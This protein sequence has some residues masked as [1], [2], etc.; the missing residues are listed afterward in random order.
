MKTKPLVRRCFNPTLWLTI[1]SLAFCLS[2]RA[3]TATANWSGAVNNDWNTAGN[4]DILGVPGV[5]TNAVIGIGTTANYDAPM[6]ATNLAGVNNTG[7]LTINAAGFN[8]DALG[9]LPAYFGNTLSLLRIT[10]NGVFVATNSTTITFNTD[11]TN[12]VDGGVLLVT[13]STG[14]IAFG[15][16]G[17]NNG[18][19]FT[20]NGG[21]VMFSQPFQSKG[22]FSRFEVHGGSLALLGGGGILE[23]SNDQERRFLIDGGTANLGNFSISRTL[24]TPIGSAGLVISNNATVTVSSL[25]IGT[26]A[27]AA[28]ATIYGGVLTNTGIFTISDRTNGATS[29]QRRIFLYVRGGTVVST[30]PSGIVIANQPNNSNTGGSSVW[31]GF[32]DINAGTIIAEQLTL[33]GTS[34][35]TNAYAT[36]TLAAPGAVYLGSG[37]LV[38]NVGYS[39]TS[40][41]MSLGGTLGAKA[42]YSI[43]GNGTLTG[44]FT[45][46]A[47]DIAN[48][49]HNVTNTGVWSGSGALVKTGGGVL[50]L[51]A[52]NTYSGTTTV[53]AGALVLGP[54]GSISNTTSIAVSSGGVFDVSAISGAVLLGSQILGGSGAVNGSI[55]ALP[56]SSIRPGGLLAAG[57]LTFSNTLALGGNVTLTFDLSDDPSGT[58][59]TNDTVNVLGSLNLS[60]TNVIAINP[61]S[62]TPAPGNVYRLIRYGTALTGGVGNLTLAGISGIL[63]NDVAGKAIV[64]VVQSSTRAPANVTWLGGLGGN[65]WDTIIT[66]NWLNGAARDIFVTGDNARFDA[67]GVANGAVTVVGS[68]NPTALVVDTAS[69]YVFSGS[70][71]ID[72]AGGLTKTNTGTLTILTTNGYSGPTMIGAG[73]IEAIRVAPGGLS[74]SLGSAGTDPANLQ[75]FDS[76]LRYLGSGGSTDR[77]ATLNGTAAALDVTNASAALTISGNLVGAAGLTKAG[78]GTLILSG[79]SG[80]AGLTTLSNGTLQVNNAVSALGTNT[81]VFVGG[82]VSFNVSGQPTYPNALNVLTSGGMTSAGGNNNIVTGPWSGAGTLNLSVASGT[83]SIGA[84]MTTNFTGTILLTTNSTGTFRFN[85]GGS[86]PSKGSTLV[87]FDLGN[88]SA[89]LVNRNGSTYGT[90]VYYLGGLAGGPN[91]TLRGSAN[92]GTPNAYEIG[93]NNRNTTFAG[94]IANGAGGSAALVSLVKAGTGTLTLSGTNTYGGSTIISNGVLALSGS[95]TI[96]ISPTINLLAGAALDTSARTDGALPLADGQTLLGEGTVRGSVTVQSNATLSPGPSAGTIGKMVITNVLT[97]QPGGMLAM[98][99]D[100]NAATNDVI[101]GLTKVI[102]GGALNLTIYSVDLTSSFRLFKAASYSGG[103]DLINPNIPAPGWVWDVSSL[104]VNGTLKVKTLVITVPKIANASISGTNITLSGIGGAPFYGYVVYSSAD[105][106]QPLSSWTAVGNGN[107]RGDGSFV[108]TIPIDPSASEQFYSVQYSAP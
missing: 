23:T 105:V 11:S 47:A 52:N 24:N 33:V 80:Y 19:G 108:F 75:L 18:A 101:E 21:V 32:L 104:G 1:I 92:N 68:V 39:N 43:V 25:Q 5:G 95:G 4:W 66:S 76:T 85:T 20:N 103:F 61:L 100:H 58:V 31:G 96:N 88:S 50:T 107:F 37:G 97:L 63:S 86:D 41:T 98:E 73:V 56:G 87:T 84:D 8:I 46:N 44:T 70:G 64:L 48:T 12:V 54:G 17:N 89:S 79:S 42:D 26:A 93:D 81:L 9:M 15:V 94:T 91:T 10:T 45:L 34:A 36:L 82:T 30:A 55:M 90:T 2:V 6:A 69:N 38:G 102:Y 27:S 49:P 71:S 3:Q 29:G 59:K 99:V 28:Q 62:G 106:K 14:N 57:Q 67:T 72:G 16:N 40:Y 74:S 51:T 13:N 7:S 83:F 78:P 60:G 35:V 22:R 77:G 53:G 65:A